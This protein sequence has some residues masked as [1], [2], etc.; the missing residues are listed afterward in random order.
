MTWG[1]KQEQERKLVHLFGGLLIVGGYALVRNQWGDRAA[2]MSLIMVLVLFFAVEYARLEL[3]API[4]FFKRFLR[5]DEEFAPSGSVPLLAGAIITF[6]AYDFLIAA[7]AM[8]MITVG[9]FAA[10]ATR[11]RMNR[12]QAKERTSLLTH[13][14]VVEF[15]TN[16]LLGFVVL[17]D[18]N[19]ALPMALVATVTEAF[20]FRLNDNL[21]VPVVSGFVGQLIVWLKP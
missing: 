9:E 10:N 20:S 21:T 15:V 14:D 8:L 6:A 3:K 1:A 16:L 19:L 18:W 17:Q 2:Q 13:A 7:A 5:P 12:F 11:I 4:H